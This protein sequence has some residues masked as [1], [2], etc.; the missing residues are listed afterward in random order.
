VAETPLSR[1]RATMAH[2]LDD[3]AAWCALPA[4]HAGKHH[5]E[6]ANLG[7]G[8]TLFDWPDPP[9]GVWMYVNEYPHEGITMAIPYATE[10]DALRAANEG[11]VG[12][13]VFVPFGSDLKD[14][15]R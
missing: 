6:L 11:D 10:T 5:A 3:R 4:G 12:K 15:L 14:M 13:A 7:A 2:P 8:P 1:C 9:A